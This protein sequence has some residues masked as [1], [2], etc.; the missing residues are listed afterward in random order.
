MF[1]YAGVARDITSTYWASRWAE[2]MNGEQLTHHMDSSDYH[3][4]R[5]ATTLPRS[6]EYSCASEVS[7]I[8]DF[9]VSGFQ[10][11]IGDSR[12]NW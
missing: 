3:R 4:S 6:G 12:F 8:Y 11:L 5:S 9:R 7:P 2:S 10:D 1:C